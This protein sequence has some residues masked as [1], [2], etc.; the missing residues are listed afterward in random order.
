MS[1]DLKFRKS[2]FLIGLCAFALLLCASAPARAEYEDYNTAVLQSLDKITARTATFEAPVGSTLSYGQVYMKVMACRKRPPIE[3]PEASAFLQIWEV[4]R[5]QESRWIFSGWMF[6][7]SPALASMD[8]PI[9]DIWVLDCKNT[10][11]ND[12]DAAAD[13]PASPSSSAQ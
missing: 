10:D 13:T 3:Q 5:Q 4:N 2:S 6:A 7:S 1:I 11:Q 12:S 8:H 9:Y